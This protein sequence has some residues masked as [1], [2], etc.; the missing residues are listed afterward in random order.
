[1]DTDRNTLFR[2]SRLYFNAFRLGRMRLPPMG[3]SADLKK[4]IMFMFSQ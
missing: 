2:D 4:T 1:M 3:L